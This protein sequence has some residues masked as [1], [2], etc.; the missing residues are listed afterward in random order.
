MSTDTEHVQTS[1]IDAL[2]S[3]E[4]QE[5][6]RYAVTLLFSPYATT[7]A[8][9]LLALICFVQLLRADD[10]T[11]RRRRP[12]EDGTALTKQ[13]DGSQDKME[14]RW[15]RCL[16]EEA[17]AAL[18]LRE[19]DPPNLSREHGGYTDEFDDGVYACAGCG[20]VVYH[21]DAKFHAGCGWPCF[22]TC[23]RRA[24][25]ER[26]DRDGVRSEIVCNACNG[27]LGHLFLNEGFGNPPP[28][29]RHCVNSRSLTFIRD[30]SQTWS[31]ND[32][33][34]NEEGDS[35]APRA[36]REEEEVS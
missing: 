26:P 14:W 20:T 5:A 1:L 23:A 34:D 31:Q 27:H 33:E 6:L 16:S 29:E 28:D 36:A 4:L 7:A 9:A 15:R 12:P 25:R 11:M 19:T 30:E 21:S 2:L 24:V 10:P 17:Y 13:A 32:D 22:Y 35:D 18:R 3:S 8:G